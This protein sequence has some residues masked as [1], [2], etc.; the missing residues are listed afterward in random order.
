MRIAAREPLQACWIESTRGTATAADVAATRVERR[1]IDCMT[2][3][4]N[5]WE[6]L[7]MLTTGRAAVGER[8]GDGTG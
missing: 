3:S 8:A 1:V 6:R 4:S 7:G 2:S 5:M